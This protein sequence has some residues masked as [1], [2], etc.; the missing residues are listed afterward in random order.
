[1]KSLNGIIND[2][3][4]CVLVGSFI[5][6]AIIFG[7]G[8]ISLLISKFNWQQS[9]NIVRSALLIIGPLGMILG[10][11]LILKKRDEKELLFIDQWKKRYRVFS[12]KIVLITVSL[13][14]VLYGGII[15]WIIV[16]SSIMN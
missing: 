2:F 4:K 10:A 16:N 12:Y 14:I 11:L 5:S 7:L 8:V 15:D 9:L 6:L 3:A 1:M 13:I